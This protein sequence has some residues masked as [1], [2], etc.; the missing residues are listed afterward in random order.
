MII[1]F[2]LLDQYNVAV[3]WDL[4]NRHPTSDMDGTL[5]SV[6]S[7]KDGEHKG[8]SS[9]MCEQKDCHNPQSHSPKSPWNRIELSS[10]EEV[11]T[12]YHNTIYQVIPS[13]L[14]MQVDYAR[15]IRM[16]GMKALTLVPRFTSMQREWHETAQLQEWTAIHPYPPHRSV[17]AGMVCR[18]DII[19]IRNSPNTTW[20]HATVSSSASKTMA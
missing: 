7:S 9:H 13:L 1:L 11:E 15:L 8:C 5:V 16:K 10:S 18:F 4:I 12:Q 2:G 17:M 14:C 19:T 6:A 3:S 20:L